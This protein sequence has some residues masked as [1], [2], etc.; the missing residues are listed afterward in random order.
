MFIFDLHVSISDLRKLK[1]PENDRRNR[2]T[3]L[4]YYADINYEKNII[5]SWPLC[6]Y[7]HESVTSNPAQN[8]SNT[9]VI[10]DSDE[11][12]SLTRKSFIYLVLFFE[13]ILRFF[14]LSYKQICCQNYSCIEF[15]SI[16]IPAKQPKL[17]NSTMSSSL[18]E[19]D[20]INL[21]SDEEIDPIKYYIVE[22][23]DG[24]SH[25]VPDYCIANG[26]QPDPDIKLRPQ[27]RIVARRK[28]ELL[29][30]IR[31]KE[32]DLLSMYSNDDSA[33]Y[34]GIISYERL[35]KDGCWH[36]LIFFDDGH[37]QYV[38]IDRIRVVFGN[39]ESK[40]VH[41]NARRFYDYYFNGV[42]QSRLAEILFQNEQRTFVFF[43]GQVHQAKMISSNS[44][45]IQ[46]HFPKSD[47]YEWLY[48]GSPRFQPIWKK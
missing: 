22:T 7:K 6:Q 23:F 20:V 11:E 32:G 17:M 5:A 1:H 33:F 41:K 18:C 24:K 10:C 34:P 2:R 43:N 4:L 46:L 30:S 42:K 9:I 21:D 15:G 27:T 19:S 12:D 8:V 40:Y 47:H 3:K 26:S 35:Q 44:R 13:R 28:P 16:F 48:A 29:P 25:R 38:P 45:L 14:F 36:Y 37:A 39:Y 31:A